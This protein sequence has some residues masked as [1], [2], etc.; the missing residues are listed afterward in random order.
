M[1]KLFLMSMAAA[2]LLASCSNDETVEM[3]QNN[4][5]IG[6]SNAFVNNSTRSIDDPSFVN[7]IT[8]TEHLLNDFVVYGYVNEGVLFNEEKV[9][10]E[11]TTKEG[12]QEQTP[13]SNWKH[14]QIEYWVPGNNYTFGAIAPYSVSANISDVNLVGNSKD[15]VGMNVAFTNTDEKQIDLLH[16]APAQIAGTTV[17]ENYNTPVGMT[18]Y[19]QLSK[20]K[21]SFLNAV[22]DGYNVKV[23]NVK[24]T[25]GYNTGTLTIS[26]AASNT[27]SAQTRTGDGLVL[28]FGNVADEVTENENTTIVN[29]ITIAN[30]KEKETYNEKLMIPMDNTAEYTVTFEVLLFKGDVCLNPKENSDYKPYAHTASIK[31]VELKLGYCYDFKATLTPDNVADNKLHPIEF[32][33]T[34][35]EDWNATD[36]DKNEVPGYESP[37]N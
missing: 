34:K 18:F 24:I 30:G 20:V 6:F 27:W 28:N 3:A 14:D 10:R 2:A 19:H 9:Y 12:V 23:L 17:V 13:T 7:D 16:A 1:K 11:Y 29:P 26:E 31:Q 36:Q 8:A 22:G 33:V 15:K 21:F 5:A 32:T 35:I 37:S 25:N 4:K